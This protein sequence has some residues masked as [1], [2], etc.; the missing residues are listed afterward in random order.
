MDCF[1][2]PNCFDYFDWL[3]PQSQVIQLKKVELNQ[4]KSEGSKQ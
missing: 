1:Y 4:K 2:T 3:N